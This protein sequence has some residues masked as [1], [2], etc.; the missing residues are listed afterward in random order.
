MNLQQICRIPL[1]EKKKKFFLNAKA[2]TGIYAPFPVASRKRRRMG[3][4]RD[5]FLPSIMKKNPFSMCLIV[6][7]VHIVQ[8]AVQIAGVTKVSFITE[9][10]ILAQ[11]L[12]RRFLLSASPGLLLRLGLDF[13]VALGFHLGLARL[14]RVLSLLLADL[15]DDVL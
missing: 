8:K 5:R 10:Q 4:Y 15:G 7:V 12:R 6:V 9:T 14:C 11:V 1:P 3:P 2:Q 13:L